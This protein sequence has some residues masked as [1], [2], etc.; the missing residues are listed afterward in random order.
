MEDYGN[1]TDDEAAALCALEQCQGRSQEIDGLDRVAFAQALAVVSEMIHE[2][3]K[4]RRG[5]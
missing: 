3:A 5:N 1:L 2:A 4:K